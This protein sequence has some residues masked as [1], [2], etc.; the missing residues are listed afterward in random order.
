[1]LTVFCGRDH[2]ERW[3]SQNLRWTRTHYIFAGVL[4]NMYRVKTAYVRE[5]SSR[6]TVRS[7]YRCSGSISPA[8]GL[9]L[10]K[11]LRRLD[12]HDFYNDAAIE[13]VIGRVGRG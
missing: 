4:K 12:R 5:L 1:M 9:E 3:G 11:E 10:L 13:V 7:L 8:R 6:W 2:R